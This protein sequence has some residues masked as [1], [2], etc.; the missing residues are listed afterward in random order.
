LAAAILL[1]AGPILALILRSWGVGSFVFG[2]GA[3]VLGFV[4]SV[5]E[6]IV[7]NA[8]SGSRSY[9]VARSPR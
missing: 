2:L 6:R 1:I 9:W 7:A 3:I 5:S 4:R 8:S